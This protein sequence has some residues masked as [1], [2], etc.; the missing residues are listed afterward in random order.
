MIHFSLINIILHHNMGMNCAE[1]PIN[2]TWIGGTCPMLVKTSPV[3][4]GYHV[5]F[6]HQLF[7]GR[8]KHLFPCNLINTGHYY[9]SLTYKVPLET[10]MRHVYNDLIIPKEIFE[11]SF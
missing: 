8:N 11:F 9:F 10:F 4:F 5:S 2:M 3:L 6:L 1:D 7:C